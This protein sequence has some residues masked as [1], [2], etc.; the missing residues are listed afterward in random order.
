MLD[1][2]YDWLEYEALIIA[3]EG[4][5]RPQR[6]LPVKKRSGSSQ[7]EVSILVE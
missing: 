4:L 2:N 6:A 1:R 5:A 3:L 7:L